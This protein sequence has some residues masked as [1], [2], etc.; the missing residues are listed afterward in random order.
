MG[1]DSR[2]DS[3]GLTMPSG[4]VKGPAICEWGKE[5]INLQR[6]CVFGGTSKPMHGIKFCLYTLLEN[7]D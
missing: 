6:L 7:C 3:L 5:G 1:I 2:Q 4:K